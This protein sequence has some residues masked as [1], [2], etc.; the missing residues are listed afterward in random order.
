MIEVKD[1]LD[2]ALSFQ[3]PPQKIVSLVPSLS[4][5]IVD[6]GGLE[7]LVAVTKFCIS[8]AEMSIGGC[9]LLLWEIVLFLKSST[10]R[11]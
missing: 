3:N 9:W 11:H 7:K 6:L 5:L 4:E 8:S 10:A 1:D 2:R